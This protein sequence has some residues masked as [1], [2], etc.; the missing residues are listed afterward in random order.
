MIY[1][2][3]SMAEKQDAFS[4]DAKIVFGDFKARVVKAGVLRSKVGKFDWNY[5]GGGS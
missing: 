3:A 5:E 4:Y 1:V 2:Y